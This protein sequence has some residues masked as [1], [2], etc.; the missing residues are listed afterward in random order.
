[1]PCYRLAAALFELACGE[2]TTQAGSTDFA[3]GPVGGR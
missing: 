3:L 2:S 1:M